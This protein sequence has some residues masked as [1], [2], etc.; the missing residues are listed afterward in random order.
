MRTL[1]QINS[2]INT[3]STGRIAEQIGLA[4]KDA[5]WESYISYGRYGNES[6]SRV[7]KVGNK[8]DNYWHVAQTRLLDRHG[9]ASI[10]ATQKFIKQIEEIQPDVIHLHN[11]HGYYVN[12][13]ILFEYLNYNKAP[14]V[15][16]L[17]DCWP[18]T[19]HCT[20][21]EYVHCDKW[22]MHCHHC[23][24]TIS[25]PKS[26]FDNSQFNFIQKKKVFSGLDNLTLVPVSRWL[27]GELQQSFLKHYPSRQIYNGIDLTQFKL[28]YDLNLREKYGLKR[29]YVCLGVASTWDRRKG[30]NDFMTLSKELTDD[31]QILLVGLS[32]KQINELPKNIIGIERTESIKELVEMYNLADVFVNPTY[33]DNFPTTNIESLACG[34]PV[35]TYRTGGSTE[36]IDND[37]G[38]AIPKGEVFALKE[39]I[40]KVCTT[41]KVNYSEKCRARAMKFFDKNERFHEYIYLYRKLLSER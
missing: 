13:K 32:K 41:G 6:Q 24:Q 27:E 10:K 19:G 35:I 40:K 11:I 9:L 25:Y 37:T 23:P 28:I 26:Y 8:L 39:M 3:G 21:Y 5:G 29:K 17:H 34:T 14:V 15:W 33:E 4:V 18:F 20:Y 22:K 31:F 30:I 1:L 12:Y 2:V 7:I 36:A 16:T 38:V